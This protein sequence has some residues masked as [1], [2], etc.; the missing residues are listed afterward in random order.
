MKKSFILPLALSAFIQFANAQSHSVGTPGGLQ[1]PETRLVKNFNSSWVNMLVKT[2]LM[3]SAFTEKIA[4]LHTLETNSGETASLETN[5]FKTEADLRQSEEIINLAAGYI[6]KFDFE[7]AQKILGRHIIANPGNDA[8]RYLLGLTQLSRGF[9]GPAASNFSKINYR[10]AH[11][12]VSGL[13]EFRD[14]VRFYYAIA[15]TMIPGGKS[16]AKVLFKQLDHEDSAYK[17]ICREMAELL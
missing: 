14:D 16:I 5:N 6:E 1:N 8:A 7:S 2:Q 10:L 9:Y 4:L 3:G 13:D 11:S 15:V 12:G 17:S